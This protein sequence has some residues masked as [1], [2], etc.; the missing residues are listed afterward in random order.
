M[1][2]LNLLSKP[3]G[4]AVAVFLSEGLISSGSVPQGLQWHSSCSRAHSF[5]AHRGRVWEEP[6]AAWETPWGWNSAQKPTIP[7]AFAIT[8]AFLLCFLIFPMPQT[9]ASLL[10]APTFTPGSVLSLLALA[11]SV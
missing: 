1:S 6:V 8:D 5:L 7:W 10:C 9:S 2:L 11:P 3:N 4:S